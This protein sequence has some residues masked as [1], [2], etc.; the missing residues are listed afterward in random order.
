MLLFAAVGGAVALLLCSVLVGVA[1]GLISMANRPPSF[2]TAD[3][4]WRALE[5]TWSSELVTINSAARS[6][7][8][9]TADRQMIFRSSLQG[10]VLPAPMTNEIVRRVNEVRLEGDAIGLMI[11]G[12]GGQP[13][14]PMMVR[15]V[16]KNKIVVED[17]EP[18]TRE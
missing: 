13:V 9:F 11:D 16:A 2:Q 10:G 3:E 15:F 12:P 5:G 17:G 6:Y 18:Y 14:G 7:W 8:Q 1:I 4:A